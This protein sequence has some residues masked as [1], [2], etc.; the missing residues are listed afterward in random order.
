MEKYN[1]ATERFVLSLSKS[2]LSFR[3]LLKI[4]GAPLIFYPQRK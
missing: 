1:A 2:L 3:E 4:T